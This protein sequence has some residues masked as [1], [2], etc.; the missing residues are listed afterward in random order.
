MGTAFKG[1]KMAVI[2]A[3][4]VINDREWAWTPISVWLL[5]GLIL[6]VLGL[7]KAIWPNYDDKCKSIL[8]AKPARKGK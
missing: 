5:I 8:P 7:L 2:G 1:I 4:L 6:I 3:L